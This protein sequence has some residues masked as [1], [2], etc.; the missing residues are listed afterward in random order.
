MVHGVKR[1]SEGPPW[2]TYRSTSNSSAHFSPIRVSPSSVSTSSYLV[3]DM[4]KMTCSSDMFPQSNLA[5]IH[6]R[7]PSLLMFLIAK[8]T[9]AAS[10]SVCIPLSRRTHLRYGASPPVLQYFLSIYINSEISSSN[11]LHHL[12]GT[13]K[14]N[15]IPTAYWA[16]SLV[17]ASLQRIPTSSPRSWSNSGF[18]SSSRSPVHRVPSANR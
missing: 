8:F 3:S 2:L 18:T 15:K 10:L 11:R 17:R 6:P 4:R 14:L 13:H 1:P 5:L 9:L 7:S 16:T 12:R